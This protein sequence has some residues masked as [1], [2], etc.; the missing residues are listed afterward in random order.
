MC[1]SDQVDHGEEE[2]TSYQSS[3]ESEHDGNWQCRVVSVSWIDCSPASKLVPM[4]PCA[5]S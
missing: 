4:V 3:F 5:E 2:S 1:S